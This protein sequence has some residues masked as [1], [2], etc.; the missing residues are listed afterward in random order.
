MHSAKLHN[1]PTSADRGLSGDAG[2][3][4]AGACCGRVFGLDAVHSQTAKLRCVPLAE[5]KRAKQGEPT[6]LKRHQTTMNG[7]VY[8]CEGRSVADDRIELA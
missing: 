8:C 3:G 5:P 2:L 7:I 4:D 1:W 6:R